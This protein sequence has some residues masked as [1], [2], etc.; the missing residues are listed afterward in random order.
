M[1][2]AMATYEAAYGGKAYSERRSD[3]L[4]RYAT[5]SITGVSANENSSNTFMIGRIAVPV[6]NDIAATG[7]PVW[8]DVVEHSET[9]SLPAGYLE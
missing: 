8:L 3:D 1:A 4:Q 2:W 5:F 9:V 7:N 6:N